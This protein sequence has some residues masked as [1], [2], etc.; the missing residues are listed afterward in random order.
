MIVKICGIKNLR[1]LGII[2]KYADFGGVVV[3]SNSKRC[4]ELA[5]A[6]E[7]IAS[8]TIPIFVVSTSEKL[9]E[10]E[11]IIAK[12][13]CDFV[14]VHGELSVEDFEALKSNVVAMKAFIV[15][16]YREILRKIK[17]YA[18]HYIL[19]DSGYGSGKTHEWGIS[20]KV[21]KEYPIILAGG[22]N[23][24]N[25]ELAIKEVRPFGVDVSTGVEKNGFKDEIL[26]SEFVRVVRNA[27]W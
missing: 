25:V 2:E 5:T 17:K 4:V 6:K 26:V 7:I 18:P 24:S 13:E 3:M 16:D 20:K 8:A 23:A 12:T 1:E 10:W 15:R 19:L 27:F 9:S 21:A 14:Q 22:L 11:Q